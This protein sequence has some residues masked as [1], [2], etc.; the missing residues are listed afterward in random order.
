MVGRIRLLPGVIADAT[1]SG[2]SPERQGSATLLRALDQLPP[3]PTPVPY[4]SATNP[5][6]ALRGLLLFQV[7][8]EPAVR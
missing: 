8:I 3:G 7:K 6:N 1:V 2:P 4:G 5:C